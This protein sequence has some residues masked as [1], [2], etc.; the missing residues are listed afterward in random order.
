MSYRVDN[1]VIYDG[2]SQTGSVN[3][4]EKTIGGPDISDAGLLGK[5]VND[6]A[7]TNKDNNIYVNGG[8]VKYV[9][10]VNPE[11]KKLSNTDEYDLT[12]SFMFD[13]YAGLSAEEIMEK[14]SARL[15]NITVEEVNADWDENGNVTGA[16]ARRILETAL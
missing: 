16:V 7:G 11:G 4:V 1:T 10:Y 2:D 14:L 15:D 3:V 12:D 5:S 8:V 13:S 9:V 6:E